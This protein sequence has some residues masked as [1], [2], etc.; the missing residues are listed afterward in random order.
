MY[1]IGGYDFRKRC[2]RMIVAFIYK[3]YAL[4]AFINH[5]YWQ[6]ELKTSF[7]NDI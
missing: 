3:Q 7:I 6:E 2:T 5:Y 4:Y 1:F